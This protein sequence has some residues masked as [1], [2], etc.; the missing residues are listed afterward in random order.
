MT[1]IS[2]SGLHS[3]NG[4]EQLSSQR[5]REKKREE[6]MDSKGGGDVQSYWERALAKD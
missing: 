1:E 2:I 4:G 6:T 5:E 3:G